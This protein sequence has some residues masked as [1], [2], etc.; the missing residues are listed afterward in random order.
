MTMTESP[1]PTMKELWQHQPVEV[2]PMSLEKIR[3]RAA[4]FEKKIWWRNLREYVGGAIAAALFVSFFIK[5]H[6]N[7]FRL[8]C[9]L[10]IAGL[11]YMAYSAPSAD[12]SADPARRSRC[13]KLASVSPKR[14]GTAAGFPKT[15][16]EMVSGATGTRF[17][18][19]LCGHV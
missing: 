4:K 3:A 8:A 14:T 19:V 16:L 9:V 18:G 6:D 1:N 7:L 2:V 15:H 11:A 10:M 5:S 12:S 17:G 13:S